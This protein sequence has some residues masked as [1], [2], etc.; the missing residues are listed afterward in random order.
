M[1]TTDNPF[2]LVTLRMQDLISSVDLVTVSF[3]PQVTFLHTE[4]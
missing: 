3:K 2:L 1:Q 4:T